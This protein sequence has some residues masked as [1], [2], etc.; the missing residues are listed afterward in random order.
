LHKGY[1]I[2][3]TPNYNLLRFFPALTISKDSIVSMCGALKSVLKE[4]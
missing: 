4:F 3:T 2:G 1:F